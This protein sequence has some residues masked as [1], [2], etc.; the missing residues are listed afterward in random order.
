MPPAE[1]APAEVVSSDSET[2]DMQ[3]V[4]AALTEIARN[5]QQASTSDT[6]TFSKSVLYAQI[7]ALMEEARDDGRD[8][9]LLEAELGASLDAAEQ[10]PGYTSLGAP[11]DDAQEGPAFRSLSAEGDESGGARRAAA[12]RV[13]PWRP[14]NRHRSCAGAEVEVPSGKKQKRSEASEAPRDVAARLLQDLEKVACP[15]PETAELH[16]ECVRICMLMMRSR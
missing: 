1:V 11:S 3:R 10:G 12:S 7:L 8:N 15:L 14:T 9:G 16:D 6:V 5:E 13:L 2:G 4:L